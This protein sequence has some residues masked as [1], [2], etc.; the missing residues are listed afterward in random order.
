MLVIVLCCVCVVRENHDTAVG[1]VKMCCVCWERGRGRER[2]RQTERETERRGERERERDLG[3]VNVWLCACDTVF[4]PLCNTCTLGIHV[5]RPGR[6]QRSL[7]ALV[8]HWMCMPVCLCT[9]ERMG[10][11][12]SVCVCKC[13]CL[14][15]CVCVCTVGPD[16]CGPMLGD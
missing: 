6:G 1:N 12:L 9:S 8:C 16:R 13:R 14:C 11:C 2:E 10:L 15:M 4:A 5:P 7:L 3:E